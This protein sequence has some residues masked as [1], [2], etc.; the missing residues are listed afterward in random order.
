MGRS[1]KTLDDCGQECAE[2]EQR[3]RRA[4]ERERRHVDAG[5]RKSHACVLPVKVLIAPVDNV[6]LFPG[7]HE[8]LFFSVEKPRV[9]CG[10]G[11]Q[12]PADATEYDG[13]GALDD[14]QPSPGFKAASGAHGFDPISN[15]SAES[16]GETVAAVDDGVALGLVFARP[17]GRDDEDDAG[18]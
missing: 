1:P 13:E 6:A 4:E 2:A 17:D 5:I 7:S 18:H 3:N 9:L 15:Q 14:E 11:Q 16:T 10:A 8:C 12:T